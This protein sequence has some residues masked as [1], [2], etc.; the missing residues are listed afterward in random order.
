MW[1]ISFPEV[2]HHGTCMLQSDHSSCAL[3]FICKMPYKMFKQTT[4]VVAWLATLEEWNTEV[5]LEN[6]LLLPSDSLNFF[7]LAGAFMH[8]FQSWRAELSH[9]ETARACKSNRLNKVSVKLFKKWN[10]SNSPTPSFS[11]ITKV[12]LC[13]NNLYKSCVRQN[14]QI[15]PLAVLFYVVARPFTWWNLTHARQ[16]IWRHLTHMPLRAC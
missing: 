5:Q 1:S 12:E 6:A 8:K 16:P 13:P 4:M 2:V 11:P 14:I 15:K 7:K 10:I 9:N 3:W